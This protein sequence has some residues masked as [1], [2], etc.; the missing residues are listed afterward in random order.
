M[1]NAPGTVKGCKKS[2]GSGVGM[3]PSFVKLIAATFCILLPVA[4]SAQSQLEEAVA[5]LRLNSDPQRLETCLQAMEN[6]F[7]AN[8]NAARIPLLEEVAT[9][10]CEGE[11]A[12]FCL[13]GPMS[14]DTRRR[15]NRFL[16][17]RERSRSRR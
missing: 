14:L 12:M 3:E 8:R 1:K 9:S 16:D 2:Y 11:A 7:P 4:A 5:L 15:C 6:A 13:R 10:T 17:E